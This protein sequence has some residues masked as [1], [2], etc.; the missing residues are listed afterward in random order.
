M[1]NTTLT[2]IELYEVHQAHALG[3]TYQIPNRRGRNGRAYWEAR[4]E[5][6]CIDP[7]HHGTAAAA[8]RSHDGH[9]QRIIN[10]LIELRRVNA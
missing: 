4:C 8:R 3:V 7:E 1:T 6:G 2:T 10:A 5:C 9:V